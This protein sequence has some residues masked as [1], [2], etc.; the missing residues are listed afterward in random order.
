MEKR[1]AFPKRTKCARLPHAHL[2]KALNFALNARIFPAK[3]PSVGQSATVTAPI[4]PANKSCLAG[5]IIPYTSEGFCIFCF[6][7]Y[8]ASRKNEK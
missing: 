4:Y 8:D 5:D 2:A 3:P 1:D 7:H 6:P